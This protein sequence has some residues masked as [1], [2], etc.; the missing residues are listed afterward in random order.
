MRGPKQ[1]CL[2]EPGSPD[3][4]DSAT[5]MGGAGYNDY[6]AFKGL[7]VIQRVFL[8]PG[9]TFRA[10]VDERLR[11]DSA[12]STWLVVETREAAGRLGRVF[13]GTEVLAVEAASEALAPSMRSVDPLL[14]RDAFR[15]A[16]GAMNDSDRNEFFPSVV[17]DD[18]IAWESA[19]DALDGLFVELALAG[20]DT[21]DVLLHGGDLFSFDV[22]RRWE[23]LEG[24]ES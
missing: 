24:I 19:L 23:A 7:R 22:R 3:R 15:S 20:F 6:A 13:S 1:L 9:R 18:P 5:R 17:A 21:T 16:V 11:R 12:D 2:V 4:L 10:S 8:D 14:R